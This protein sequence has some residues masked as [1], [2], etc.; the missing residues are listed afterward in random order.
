MGFN[1]NFDKPNLN[2]TAISTNMTVKR[3]QRRLPSATRS[4]MLASSSGFVLT[5]APADPNAHM[6]RG[7]PAVVEVLVEVGVA[8]D[9]GA[10]HLN[11][12][13]QWHNKTT[14]H[15]PETIW[16]SSVPQASNASGWLIDKMNAQLNPIDANL[17]SFS[18]NCNPH[19]AT[20]GVHLHGVQEGGAEYNGVEGQ[21]TIASVDTALLSVGSATAVPTPLATPDP[22]GGMHY[23]LY[24][25]IWNTNYPFWYGK[26]G[27]NTC[28]FWK[29]ERRPSL[30]LIRF[31]SLS[32]LMDWCA[33]SNFRYPFV[34]EDRSS[35]FRFKMRFTPP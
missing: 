25:N 30:F 12:T 20:C 35:K 10:I 14:T 1:G 3:F 31:V 24:G 4:S 16:V 2:L 19:R 15:A 11:Y 17:S 22:R 6:V 13:V 23:A 28:P 18:G 27:R 32:L 8:A 34:D 5:M 29:R 26:K 9:T 21:I 33:C 7:A